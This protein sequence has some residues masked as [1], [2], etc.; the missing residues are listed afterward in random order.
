MNQSLV[1]V[2]H[3]LQIEGFVAVVRKGSILVEL[4]V[5]R[6]YVINR[7]VRLDD[8]CNKDATGKVATV[9]DEVDGYS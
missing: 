7:A 6:D 5:E 1:G 3:L 9:R 2:H 8:L 4:L